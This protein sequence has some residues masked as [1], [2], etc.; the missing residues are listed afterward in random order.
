MGDGGA[1]GQGAGGQATAA[2]DGADRRLRADVDEPA[3]SAPCPLGAAAEEGEEDAPEAVHQPLPAEQPCQV[4]HWMR[5]RLRA[6]EAAWRRIGATPE[7]MR[8]VTEGVEIPLVSWPPRL[9][10]C[11]NHGGADTHAEW[12]RRAIAEMVQCGVA[13]AVVR[14]PWVVAPIDV[15]PKP[16]G[17]RFRL[18]YD[19]RDLN[20][21]T[22]RIKFK[23]ES[24]DGS[25]GMFREGDWLFCIDFESGYYHVDIREE[26]QTLL[27]F[28]YEGKYYVFTQLPFGTRDA[29]RQFTVLVR[30]PV[31]HLRRLGYR[32]LPYIDDIMTALARK[33]VSE[34]DFVVQFFVDLG[35]L[36]SLKKPEDLELAQRKKML[37]WYVDTRRMCFELPPE[38]AA[39]F[40]SAAAELEDLW[41]VQQAAAPAR[42]VAKPCG[43]VASMA[44]VLG[45]EARL[46]CRYMNHT[47]RDVARRASWS[48][49]VEGSDEAI[50]ELRHWRQAIPGLP[51]APIARPLPRPPSVVLVTDASDVQTGGGIV[52]IDGHRLSLALRGELACWAPFDELERLFGSALRELKGVLNVCEQNAALCCGRV[53]CVR[54]DAF[55]AVVIYDN[56]GSQHVDPVTGRLELHA[57]VLALQQWSDGAGVD[58]LRLEW[59]PREEGDQRWADMV[60]KI[61]DRGDWGVSKSVFAEID[62]AWGPHEIDCFA[63]A[64]NAQLPVFHTRFFTAHAAHVDT[65]SVSW[66]GACVWLVPDAPLVGRAVEKLRRDGAFGAI[67]VPKWP[68]S[69][70]WPLLFGSPPVVLESRLLADDPSCFVAYN[71]QT[72][73]S[74]ERARMSAFVACRFDARGSAGSEEESLGG[75]DRAA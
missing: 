15:I 41:A 24:L 71:D 57:A 36:I 64:R 52:E 43:H 5:G 3:P 27:G 46:R 61:E 49:R 44:L 16:D 51:S 62:A 30:Q 39:K 7:V 74:G 69:P 10:G 55:A 14:R 4:R 13:R 26:H 59:H 38:R 33:D 34:R 60:S 56:G 20:S 72:I 2:D 75:G 8:W 25:R 12:A 21:Y 65:F 48:E 70:W 22:K 37:G 31:R 23:Y 1:G 9:G 63:S 32:L 68:G 58:E 47:L 50:V 18:V 29:C 11:R 6:R 73:V 19:A 67:I 17:I 45:R 40:E 42:L 28:F 35:F 53:V 54:T 66:A